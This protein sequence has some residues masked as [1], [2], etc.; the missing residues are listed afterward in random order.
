MDTGDETN[1]YE[2]LLKLTPAQALAA[3]VLDAGGSQSEA[4]EM[5]GVS[6]VTISRWTHHHPAFVAELNRRYIERAGRVATRVDELTSKAM[7]LVAKSV[8]QGDTSV[9]IQ[10]L[11]ILGPLGLKN[12]DPKG[13]RPIS[14]EEIIAKAAELAA[15]AA[16]LELVSHPY[17][18][19]AVRRIISSVKSD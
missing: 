19:S 4:A 10:W 16:P 12:R 17:R 13:K 8:E 1:R 2:S 9:A 3:D 18:D 6:R 14:A 15:M 11:R 7:E 5:A